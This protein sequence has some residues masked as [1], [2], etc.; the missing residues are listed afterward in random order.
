MIWFSCTKCGKT[1]GR[2]DSGTTVFCDCG[3]GNMVPWESTT[4]A[5]AN[6]PP[7]VSPLDVPPLTAVPVGE[8]QIPVARRPAPEAWDEAPKGR[9]RGTPVVRDRES[10]FNHQDRPGVEKCA[11]CAEN[12]CADCLVK[13]KGVS[14]CGPCKNYRLRQTS[15][16]STVSGKAIFGIILAMCC[17]PVLMCLVPM[18]TN[19]FAVVVG[20][21][22]LMGQITATV[23]G[24]MA[25]RETERNPRL[26]G[27]S[28]AITTILT[29]GLAM[30]MTAFFLVA[31]Q[32]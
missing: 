2:V 21:V 1:L 8:E 24:G 12:F 29:G 32:R 11:D 17:A 18:G 26:S 13:F 31:G 10:C 30:L 27:K 7:V 5:P 6:A 9:R 20:V 15:K 16:P 22:A 4:A 3:Q 25:L 19:S 14:L 28:L 23:L